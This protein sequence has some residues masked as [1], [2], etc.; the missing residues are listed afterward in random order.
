MAPTLALTIVVLL[1]LVPVLAGDD[2]EPKTIEEDIVVAHPA[3]ATFGWSAKA[4]LDHMMDTKVVTGVPYSAQATTETVQILA[5]GNRIVHR[6]NTNI[7]RDGQGRTRHEYSFTPSGD[8]GPDGSA[9]VKMIS[10]NDPTNGA[11]YTLHTDT[12]TADKIALPEASHVEKQETIEVTSSSTAE[13]SANGRHVFI[14][15]G[16]RPGAVAVVDSGVPGPHIARY[17]FAM[18]SPRLHEDGA[19]EN[20]GKQVIEGLEVEGKR[21][22]VTIPAG[23]IGN[24]QPIMITNES[25]YSPELQVII[26]SRRDDPMAGTTTYRLTNIVRAEPDPSLFELPA[27]Y[28][29][30]SPEVGV[31]KF[32]RKAPPPRKE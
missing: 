14:H 31:R 4:S 25:W 21:T 16:A 5:D 26:F 3:G 13:A 6:S 2:G 28:T 11:T 22:T 27:D 15:K 23:Q 1:I 32:E 20:L 17:S 19:T 24:E 7:A 12:R 9:Q 18:A 29:V 10:I 8:S 30:E